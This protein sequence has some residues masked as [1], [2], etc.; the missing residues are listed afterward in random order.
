MPPK[1]EKKGGGKKKKEKAG[2]KVPDAEAEAELARK[3]LVDE[4]KRLKKVKQS[5]E[6]AF[7]EFQQQKA[8]ARGAGMG[9]GT[10]AAL[11]GVP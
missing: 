5:E 9:G 8:R 3:A 6:V 1:K 2:P 7:N 11:A 10:L 4:C